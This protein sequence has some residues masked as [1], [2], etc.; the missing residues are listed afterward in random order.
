MRTIGFERYRFEE[1]AHRIVGEANGGAYSLGQAVR[2]RLREATPLTGGLLFE[3]LSP[4]LEGE[5]KG[6]GGAKAGANKKRTK[7]RRK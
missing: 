2:V 1:R 3:L 4:P 5:G 6:K 7:R